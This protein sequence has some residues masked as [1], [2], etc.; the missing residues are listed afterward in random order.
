MPAAFAR[1]YQSSM[2]DR[3]LTGCMLYFCALLQKD[4]LVSSRPR[5][6]RRG[7]GRQKQELQCD[8]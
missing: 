6:L 2:Y 1:F 3:I 5:R 7:R 4:A 8:G